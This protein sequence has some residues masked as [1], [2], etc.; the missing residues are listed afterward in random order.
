MFSRVSHYNLLIAILTV[1]L[2]LTASLQSV[3]NRV[4]GEESAYDDAVK[5]DGTAPAVKELSLEEYLQQHI[6]KPAPDETIVIKGID[7]TAFEGDTPEILTGT[8]GNPAQAL[9]TTDS[10]A[11]TWEFNIPA[12]G[13]YNIKVRYYPYEG[14]NSTIERE[15]RID[16]AIPFR[17]ARSI[18][19]LRVW[20]DEEEIRTDSYGNEYRPEQTE[21]KKWLEQPIQAKLGHYSMA[22]PFYLDSGAH[23]ITFLSVNE[24]MLIESITLYQSLP[25][26]SYADVLADW[27]ARGYTDT[28]AAIPIR[29]EGEHA[30]NKSDPTLFPVN[31]RTSPRTFPQDISRIK[32]NAIG[33]INWRYP[34][35]WLEWAFDVEDEG[36]YMLSMR[37]KQDYVEGTSSYRKILID[38]ELLFDELS[39][40]KFEYGFRWDQK[41]VG[42]DEPFRIFLSKGRHTIR[43]ENTVG[44]I[45]EILAELENTV[46]ELNYSYR[47]IMMI[48][49]SFPDPNQDYR[50]D[51]R[52]PDSM[53]VFDAQSKK[54][55]DI[56]EQLFGIT[57]SKGTDY[58]RLI[59]LAYQLESFVENPADIP[60][61]LDNFRQNISDQSAW[62]L[63]AGEQPLLVD[64]LEFH[65]AGYPVPDGEATWYERLAFEVS[66]FLVSFVADYS[67]IGSIN[68]LGEKSKEITMWMGSISGM[69]GGTG[70]DQAQ[71]IKTMI[72]N[73]FTPQTDIL[74][75]LKLIDMSILLPA[76]A[77][78]RGPDIAFSQSRD[79][80]VNYALRNAIYDLSNFDD[81][82]TVLARFN[83]ASYESFKIGSSIYA[84][85]ETEIF[86][87]MFYRTDILAEI[88]AAVPETW[89][90][91]YRIIPVLHRNY[92][93][94]GLPQIDGNDMSALQ[95]MIY[96]SGGSYYNESRSRAVFDSRPAT[97]A[98]IEWSDLYTKYKVAVKIDAL[99]RFRTGES[100]IVIQPYTFYNA[101]AVAAP[102]INGLWDFTMVPGTK[103][104][105]GDIVHTTVSSGSGSVIFSNAKDKESSWAFLKWWT[106]APTQVNYGREIESLQGTS[107]R[108][109]TA[110]LEAFRLLPWSS[111]AYKILSLQRSQT[112]GIP[113]LPG[114]YMTDRYL[115]NAIKNVV[116]N[117]ANPRETILNWNKK[118]NDEIISKR[119]E[120]GME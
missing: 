120:F 95:M 104:A 42:A 117:G 39:A 15:V 2:V 12:S 64:Y 57:G 101:L 5:T 112:A 61:R 29:L 74:V 43:M 81:L 71:I 10:A 30:S 110:N 73:Y 94:I 58:G 60:E 85:P 19:F 65:P 45:A 100:P 99:T 116:N 44:E 52:L 67:N 21:L 63:S 89:E 106:D 109:P 17:E 88:G 48:T 14:K 97:E 9:L 86:H 114:S 62:I 35:Q 28:K 55:Y 87:M 40:V 105:D 68:D 36:Y 70:R 49:G 16:G 115:G 53:K 80:P 3:S 13:N 93:D 78:G 77:A 69:A 50:I 24:P 7:Y 27:E 59:K 4:Y 33:G 41:T 37:V 8:G 83:P 96:Q 98:F 25:A 56:A 31:D 76:V 119:T 47:K 79:L 38:D 82:D 75:N 92:M 51:A 111:R 46:Y 90:D 32:M 66:T 91:I 6:D 11:V 102:E 18:K 1:S 103:T 26:E 118:I 22:T 108:W 84:L 113:E 107:A 20:Q 23:S 54:L 34:G 72:D